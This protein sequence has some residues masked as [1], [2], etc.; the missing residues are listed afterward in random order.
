MSL[1]RIRGTYSTSV[2]GMCKKQATSRL[3][4][5]F[6]KRKNTHMRLK[7]AKDKLAS[8]PVR[9]MGRLTLTYFC[10]DLALC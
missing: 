1:K 8:K 7:I 10:K 4:L 9:A 2:A 6:T 3:E 5:R